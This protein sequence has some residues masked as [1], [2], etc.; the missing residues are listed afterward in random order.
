MNDFQLGQNIVFIFFTELTIFD[1]RKNVARCSMTKNYTLTP[2]IDT[3]HKNHA[4]RTPNES[5]FFQISQM[6]WPIGQIGRRSFE[7]FQGILGSTICSL[8][9]PSLLSHFFLQKTK[10][11]QCFLFRIGILIQAVDISRSTQQNQP[12]P[13]SHSRSKGSFNDYVDTILSLLDHHLP[14]RGHFQP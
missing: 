6:F 3:N 10:I 1:N 7:V 9:V 13:S 5:F 14:L 2:K 4:L 8:C 11:L 12:N